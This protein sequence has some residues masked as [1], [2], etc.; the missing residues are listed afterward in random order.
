[1]KFSSNDGGYLR[2]AVYEIHSNLQQI[3]KNELDY[4][5]VKPQITKQN[6]KF[7]MSIVLKYRQQTKILEFCY[8][9]IKK[10]PRNA[11]ISLQYLIDPTNY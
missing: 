2:N 11:K 8:D 1:M 7:S 5:Y 6:G 3:L 4:S 9:F 10:Y